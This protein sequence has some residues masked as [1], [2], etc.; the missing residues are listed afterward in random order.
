LKDQQQSIK[1]GQEV[2]LLI[3]KTAYEGKSLAYVDGKVCFISNVIPGDKV[4]ARIVVRKKA[5][6]EAKLIEIIEDS[7]LRIQPL[8]SHASTCGGCSWQH[9]P[10]DYQLQFK[11][12]HVQDHMRRIG[13]LEHVSVNPVIGSGKSFYY[14]NKMEYS[15][16]DRR[17]LSDEEIASDAELNK[18]ELALGLH[19][20]ARFDRILNLKECHLQ[21]L[22]S[23]QI[24]D[25]TR[26]F[27]IKQGFTPYNNVKKQGWLRH[28]TIRN[29][30][31]NDGWMVNLMTFY[32][33]PKSMDT[34]VQYLLQEFPF[35]TTIVETINSTWGPVDHNAKEIIHFGSGFITDTIGK[36]H[37]RI[38]PS[39]FFQTNTAQA[40][41]LF[42]TAIDFAEIKSGT[43]YDLYCGVGTLSLF[44]SENASKV[45]GVELN[46]QSIKNAEQN[47]KNNGVTNAHFRTGDTRETFSKALI[48][49]F[50]KP[51]VLLTDPPRAGMHG[52]VVH[53][54]IDLNIPTIVYVSCNSASMARDLALLNDHYDITH[55]QPVDMFPQ[56]YHIE[57]VARLT[58]RS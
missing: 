17:W 49:E 38:H 32:S 26:S 18:D 11:H 31:A 30:S 25:A 34:L 46:P 1:K 40:E 41:R 5:Y 8:C 39:T 53:S 28:L 13:G 51:D 55:I 56:T 7:P 24:L 3:E 4:R 36:Y 45:V 22:R 16:G 58:A 15:F 44:A 42:Q 20:P 33:D 37:F 21:D 35:I 47:A 6:Y 50:G 48:D 52:D 19:I 10:Y 9:A 29:S 54:L 14:R 12:E 57:T 27:A 2:E 23:Y 43:V